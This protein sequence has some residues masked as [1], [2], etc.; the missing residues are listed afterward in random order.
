VDGKFPLHPLMDIETIQ[1]E[2]YSF[3]FSAFSK[4]LLDFYASKSDFV[5]PA[6]RLHEIKTFVENGL[7][8]S[9]FQED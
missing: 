1:E 9:V 7:E 6:S 8:V 2:N 5:V 4:K 3:K